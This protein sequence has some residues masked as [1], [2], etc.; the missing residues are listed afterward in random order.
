MP[1]YSLKELEAMDVLPDDCNAE[2]DKYA[3]TFL[4]PGL[5]AM[6][7]LFREKSFSEG[8]GEATHLKNGSPAVIFTFTAGICKHASPIVWLD[9]NN[10]AKGSIKFY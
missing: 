4:D 2:A 6:M 3:K 10:V 7:K 9:K 8:Y 1:K 5:M